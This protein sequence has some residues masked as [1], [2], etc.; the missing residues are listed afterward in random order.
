[1]GLNDSLAADEDEQPG[2]KTEPQEQRE[3]ALLPLKN[4]LSKR[5]FALC[6]DALPPDIGRLIFLRNGRFHFFGTT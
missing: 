1:M 6:N 5:N 2:K 3:F 4:D